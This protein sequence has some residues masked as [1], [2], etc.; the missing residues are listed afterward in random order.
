MTTSAG[1]DLPRGIGAPA[2][3]A[4]AGAGYTEQ[5]QLDGVPEADLLRLHGVGPRA[6]ALLRAALWANGRSLG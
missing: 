3:R 6:T 4:L 1:G 2:I 5:A